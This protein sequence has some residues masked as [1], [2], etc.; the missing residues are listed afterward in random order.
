[1]QAD[2]PEEELSF[3][4]LG[5]LL[6]L[7]PDEAETGSRHG[8]SLRR[9]RLA[10]AQNGGLFRRDGTVQWSFAGIPVAARV[11]SGRIR[12][13][14]RSKRLFFRLPEQKKT[15][16]KEKALRSNRGAFSY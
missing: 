3:D 7:K 14:H 13:P 1:M 4:G 15:I 9:K 6:C 12:Y 2:G 10:D 5:G 8:S 16:K 11:P